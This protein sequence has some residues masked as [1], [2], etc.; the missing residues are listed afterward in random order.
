MKARA[1]GGAGVVDSPT[2]RVAALRQ[3]SGKE[4]ERLD[5]PRVEEHRRVVWSRTNRFSS[6][7]ALVC[8]VPAFR[9]FRRIVPEDLGSANDRPLT[10]AER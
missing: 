10:G 2:K 5:G 9:Q 4:P 6:E 8:I 1:C 7:F 3:F